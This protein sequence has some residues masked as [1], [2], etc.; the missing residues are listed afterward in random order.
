MVLKENL[1][2]PGSDAHSPDYRV[3]A[4]RTPI[5]TMGKRFP[6]NTDKLTMNIRSDIPGPNAY[7][8]GG[9]SNLVKGNVRLSAPPKFSI[10]KELR[11]RNAHAFEQKHK[12]GAG[13]YN[14]HVYDLK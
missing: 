9:I 14:P 6:N 3:T 8:A 13:A 5:V 4:N 11:D 12:P 10:G 1:K 2:I 7:Y